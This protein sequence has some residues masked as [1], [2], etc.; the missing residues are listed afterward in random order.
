MST[1]D[2]DSEQHGSGHRAL[3]TIF[4]TVAL[5]LLGF[6]MIL[7]LLPFYAQNF[8]AT[9]LQIGIL[10]A[11]YSLAQL[12][13]APLLGRLSDRVGRRPVLLASLFI[14]VGAYLLFAGAWSFTVL[15][16]ARTISGI[17]AANY[18]IAQA[19]IAD[20]TPPEKR[21][22]GMGLVGAA[23]GI[24]FVL[25]PALGGLLGLWSEAAVPL[26]AAVL[27]AVNFLLALS[28]LPESLPEEARSR[29]QETPWLN[30]RGLATLA[31]DLPV[32]G[33]MV[34]FFLVTLC[35]SLMEATLALYCQAVFDFGQVQTSWLFVFIG[36]VLVAVQGGMVGRLVGRFGER[37]LIPAGIALMAMGLLLLPSVAA[38]WLLAGTTALLALG[39]G[40]HNPS[41]LGM[42]SRLTAQER[43]GGTLGL[44]RS[45]G[46]LARV[47][48][49]PAGTWLFGR[50]SIA[51]PF[52]AAGTLMTVTFLLAL[53]LV[54]RLP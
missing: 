7:P 26:G 9:P 54:R 18:G 38:I 46:A 43:Q 41:S 29:S 17:A 11:S 4:I 42:L 24:G 32:L 52:W 31:R 13:F 5:D 49:P 20:V 36:V 1:S 21:A 15:L 6:G 25:G 44:S 2:R 37:R 12:V 3:T 34:L 23:F 53:A 33:L 8:G 28:W 48:G 35:F 40:I 51:S 39:S 22:K 10:F 50:V 16:V 45:F 19:Y 27:A 14:G 47:L 30:L